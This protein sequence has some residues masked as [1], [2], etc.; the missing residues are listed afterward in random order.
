M[1]KPSHNQKRILAAVL[2]LIGVFSTVNY[3]FKLGI[4]G[5]FGRQVYA[6]TALL[7][8]IC[9]FFLGAFDKKG[10]KQKDR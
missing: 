3:Y 8:V 9:L 2:F 6:V 7:L 1:T 10:Q 5:R 4:F